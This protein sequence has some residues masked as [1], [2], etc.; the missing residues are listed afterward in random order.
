MTFI[1]P[2]VK[3]RF[4]IFFHF[5]AR[6]DSPILIKSLIKS[7]KVKKLKIKSLILKETIVKCTER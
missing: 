2:P 7:L 1:F 6:P 3:Y 4:K 5:A